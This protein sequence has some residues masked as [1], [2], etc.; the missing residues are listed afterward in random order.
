MAKSNPTNAARASDDLPSQR[1]FV[2]GAAVNNTPDLSKQKSAR[3]RAIQAQVHEVLSNALKC[4]EDARKAF[5]VSERC[6][7][8]RL[9]LPPGCTEPTRRRILESF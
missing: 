5:E 4:N 6:P 3:S 9:E 8:P 1:R 2:G 7:L